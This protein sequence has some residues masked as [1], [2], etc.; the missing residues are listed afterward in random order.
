MTQAISSTS[1]ST[2]AGELAVLL[3]E[4]DSNRAESDRLERDSAR[5]VFLD[6]AQH[7]VDA[8]HAA[9]DATAAGALIS[10]AFSVASG[11]FS[12]A[13]ASSQYDADLG[14]ASGTP[15]CQIASDQFDANIEN[16]EAKLYGAFGEAGKGI[17]GDSTAQDCQADAKH[18]ETLAAQSQWQASDAS[19]DADKADKQ[20]DKVLEIL[21]GIQRDQNSA[22]NAIIGR[23]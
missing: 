13:A 2:F 21:Q 12:I 18:F 16:A 20:M 1:A 5:T 22:N 7:Q 19:S 9:A 6:N 10:G 11:A 14:K 15:G 8:L 23:I 3:I 4:T 17:F